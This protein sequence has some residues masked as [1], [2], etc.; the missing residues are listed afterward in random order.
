MLSAKLL[1]ENGAK[2]VLIIATHGLFSGD[3]AE[4]MQASEYI[5]TIVVTN[6]VD[7]S[8]AVVKCPKIKVVDIAPIIA[9]AIRRVHNYESVA[10]L[11]QGTKFE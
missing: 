2:S 1:R 11:Y 8:A 3:A 10:A 5:D 6:T 9:E 7:I 4:R